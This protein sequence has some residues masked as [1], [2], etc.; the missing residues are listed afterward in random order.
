MPS[1][2]R[3]PGSISPVARVGICWKVLCFFFLPAHHIKTGRVKVNEVSIHPKAASYPESWSPSATFPTSFP[4][5][6]LAQPWYR[7]RSPISRLAKLSRKYVADEWIPSHQKS[8]L[9]LIMPLSQWCKTPPRPHL[10]SK[11]QYPTLP[12]ETRSPLDKQPLLHEVVQGHLPLVRLRGPRSS[13]WSV[14]GHAAAGVSR[15]SLSDLRLPNS[16][17]PEREEEQSQSA[18]LVFFEK[19]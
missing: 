2:S 3:C 12:G 7:Q 4:G 13:P 19:Y 10:T 6:R 5:L 18:L 1:T 16:S 14:Q 15:L 11:C 17:T 8:Q 9:L